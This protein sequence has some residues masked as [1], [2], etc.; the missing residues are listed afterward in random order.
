MQRVKYKVAA[1]PFQKKT[2]SNSTSAFFYE[3]ASEKRFLYS[4]SF[5][6]SAYE[7]DMRCYILEQISASCWQTFWVQYK[8]RDSSE[9]GTKG[10]VT[11][12]LMPE[13]TRNV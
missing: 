9:K 2:V 10:G 5:S 6:P 12:V 11:E 13:N 8:L 4:Y 1:W 7:V 3:K